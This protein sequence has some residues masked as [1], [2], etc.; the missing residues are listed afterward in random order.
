MSLR[1]RNIIQA[2]EADLKRRERNVARY[3][4]RLSSPHELYAFY[5]PHVRRAENAKHLLTLAR[6][7]GSAIKTEKKNT[8]LI[9]GNREL[10]NEAINLM[11]EST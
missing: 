9:Y 1:P 7:K 3:G 10:L 2:A 11:G 8:L 4:G 5:A 6:N